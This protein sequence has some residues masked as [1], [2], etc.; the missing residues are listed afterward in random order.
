MPPLALGRFNHASL[1]C[2]N[3][4]TSVAFYEAV[5][6]LRRVRRPAFDFE[7]A[8]LYCDGLGMML[9]LI[10]N[11]QMEVQSIGLTDTRRPHLAFWVDDVDD[12]L[13]TLDARGVEHRHKRLPTY[14]Y[15]QVFFCDPDDN[16]IEIGEWPDVEQMDL[17]PPEG[18]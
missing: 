17:R 7:G 4:S 15:R 6:G 13:Q 3:V 12:A 14:G 18:A 1:N 9:H 11:E 5:V 8:W 10:R 16:L 2:R